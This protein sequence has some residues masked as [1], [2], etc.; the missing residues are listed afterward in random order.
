M[1][2]EFT[3]PVPACDFG[4]GFLRFQGR[5][6]GR[7]VKCAVAAVAL[8]SIGQVAEATRRELCA[9][10]RKHWPEIERIARQKFAK[11]RPQS[12]TL[13]LIQKSDLVRYP[14]RPGM[15]R[16]GGASRTRRRAASPR[17]DAL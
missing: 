1:V 9:L 2:L 13:L 17:P 14:R 10:F 11:R 7:V 4:P 15:S 12:D 5:D 3:H 16:A 8:L 6:N